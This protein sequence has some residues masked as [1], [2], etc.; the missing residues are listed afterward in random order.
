MLCCATTSDTD[1][2]VSL[3][4]GIA[5]KFDDAAADSAN[6]KYARASVAFPCVYRSGSFVDATNFK[7]LDVPPSSEGDEAVAAVTVPQ[8]L[9]ADFNPAEG[10]VLLKASGAA[11]A[12]RNGRTAGGKVREG[13]KVKSTGY[14]ATQPKVSCSGSLFCATVWKN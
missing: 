12:G 13:S 5:K 8:S 6:S 7:F 11:S 4:T 10:S 1:V 14:G 3:R 2:L 9:V